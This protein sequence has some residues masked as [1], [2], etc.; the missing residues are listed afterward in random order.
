MKKQFSNIWIIIS[1]VLIIIIV[2]LVIFSG[3]Q[4]TEINTFKNKILESEW[5]K[6]EEEYTDVF[7]QYSLYEVNKVWFSNDSLI[8]RLNKEKK[9]VQYLLEELRARKEMNAVTIDSLQSELK[10]LRANIKFYQ[11]TIDSLKGENRQLQEDKEEAA[12]RYEEASHEVNQLQQ[13]NDELN[14][15]V[16]RAA[17]LE[18]TDVEIETLNK[19]DK[20]TTEKEKVTSLKIHFTVAHNALTPVGEKEISLRIEKPDGSLLT[21]VE[22]LEGEIQG[23]SLQQTMDYTGADKR[24]DFEWKVE[25]SLPAGTYRV[26][27]F[28]DGQQI[29]LQTFVLN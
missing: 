18:A 2:V 10:G 3:R 29:G 20:T 19:R 27:V 15:K 22:T 9:R 14:E 13:D 16:R 6:L 4:R 7:Q 11:A 1:A 8:V 23:Y 24:M 5:A 26:I 17:L 28:A 12:S 21:K 25:E